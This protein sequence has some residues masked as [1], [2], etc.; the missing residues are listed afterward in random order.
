M[1]A[2]VLLEQTDV[3]EVS[4]ASIVRTMEALYSYETTRTNIPEG[5]HLHALLR[6]DLKSDKQTNEQDK[7]SFASVVGSHITH[8]SED[9][10][11]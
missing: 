1:T 11:V 10:F 2:F 5:C 3:S 8:L 6:E 4:T 7:Y 9:V